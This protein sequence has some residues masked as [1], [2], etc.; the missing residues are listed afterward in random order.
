[1]SVEPIPGDADLRFIETVATGTV[2]IAV[3]YSPHHLG[4]QPEI[5]PDVLGGS[6]FVAMA[7]SPTVTRCGRRVFPQF[8]DKHVGTNRFHDDQLCAACYRT[9]T[10]ADQER[11]FEH[12]TPDTDGDQEEAA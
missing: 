3:K 1:V 2:H 11:A 7:V 8:E 12:E 6:A 10:P 4:R 5:A 9:L